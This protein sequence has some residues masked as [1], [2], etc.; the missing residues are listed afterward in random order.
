LQL[1]APH[2]PQIRPNRGHAQP[3]GGWRKAMSAWIAAVGLVLTASTALAQ[4]VV[5]A[6]RAKPAFPAIDLPERAQGE[7][8]IS[9]LGSRLNEV[10]AWYGM[11][12]PQFARIMRGDRTAWLDRRGRVF[13]QE[14]ILF[15]LPTEVAP[16]AS[17]P[18]SPTL[19]PLDQTFKLHS[20]PAAKRT[21]YLN[22]VGATLINTAWNTTSLPTITALPFDLDGVPYS[23]SNAELERIQYIWKRVAEDYAAFDVDVTTEPPPA[24]RLTRSGTADDTFGTTVLITKRTFY[25]C[26]CG[27]VAYL[28]VFDDVGDFFKPAL[29]FYDALGG[30][31]E[32]YVADAISHEA[33]HNMGL[34]HDGTSTAG[35]YTGHGSGATGWA[36]IMGVGY[37]QALVQW[38]K[39]EYADANNTEDDYVRM[40][41]TGLPLRAD[42]H[43][44]STSAATAMASSTAAGVTT[45]TGSGVIERQTDVDYLSFTSAA[46]SVTVS[47]S[48]SPRGPKLDILATLR[49]NA[50]TILATANP[51][52][53]LPAALTATLTTP[54]TYFVA[55]D[56]IGKGDPLTSGYT[57]YGSVG[58]YTVTVTTQA[59]ASQPPTAVLTATPTT[60]TA[61]LA[62]NFSAAGSIDADGTVV[63]YAWNF[64]DGGSQ[65]GGT[66]AQ[67][68]YATAGTYTASLTVTDN[69]GLT[70]TKSVV[71]TVQAPTSTYALTVGK[72]GSGSGTV[73][74][75]PAGISCGADCTENYSSGTSVTLTASAATGST[76]AGWS[77]ACTGTGV[78][79]VSMTAAR[80][81]TA[82]FNTISHALTVSKGGLG[83]GTV[84]SSPA[85]ISCGADCAE[86]YAYGTSVTLTASAATGST[87]AGWS[88]A[89]TGTG[90]C[91][92]SMT[93]AR[94]VTATFNTVSYDLTV[95]RAG[96]G[97]GTVSSS[98]AGINCGA[99]CAESYAY[100]T[101]VTLSASAATG[102]TFA[103]WSGACTG[104]GACTVSMT[105]ARS[106]TASFDLLRT[107]SVG[108]IAMSLRNTWGQTDAT[109]T[110]TVRDGVGV[111]VAGATVS[112]AWSGAVGGSASAVTN[113]S[114][115]ATIR[116]ARIRASN[117]STFAFTV[118]GIS[119][120]GYTYNAAANAET[121]DSITVG[122]AQ[123]PTAVLT[124]DRTAGTV[125]LTVNFSAAGSSDADGTIAS[126]A[127]TFGDGGTA[128][129]ATAQ[130]TYTVPGTYTATLTVTD[131][132]GLTDSKSVTITAG[133]SAGPS[134]VSVA[135]IG[136]NLRKGWGWSEAIATVTVRDGNGNPVPAATVTGTWSGAASGSVSLVS[137][138]SGQIQFTSPRVN[139]P[140]GSV[141]SFTVTGVTLAGYTYNPAANVET[142]DSITR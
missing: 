6:P 132:S 29:V 73:S 41:N 24:D 97:S 128:S 135:D 129:G 64:G 56:G 82:T 65:T 80:S 12:T 114:G 4:A 116:S 23:F 30:G 70:D 17:D 89:C 88:G 131:N 61:P 81:V 118:N 134:T 103:G 36:P 42:D 140:P 69:S 85:G 113:S 3:R 34:N 59:T 22:F 51:T 10:A 124:V 37:Y 111:P 53:S 28:S 33:G 32:K 46:G 35:Y 13:F 44:N 27:G 14:E 20:R 31:N 1:D 9:R 96:S 126:Y 67:R 25:N 74:S 60:G 120:S 133:S 76:F 77:G 142:T 16:L 115:V 107:T 47:V 7:Q 130:R 49:N 2:H 15:P 138:T 45:F 117:G 139:A 119:V 11:T 100:G 86:S 109:A 127:W 18:L 21:I 102:S 98:P 54:G 8:A 68:T 108:N 5:E 63:A 90:A 72:S 58:Q 55:I 38:S 91:T 99:D 75:S 83:T 78:C 93:A 40:Q 71:I 48:P 106:V 136:M 79:T 95:A 104:T 122:G 39:G 101:S 87:F 52:E 50:G 92:V 141:F 123:R 112:G 66:T 62:V 94:S 137:N 105:A 43:G 57:D 84:A 121:S 26:S 110:V 19:E 125:P